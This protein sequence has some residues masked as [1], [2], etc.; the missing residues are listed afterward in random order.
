MFM[1][2][3]SFVYNY[4]CLYLIYLNPAEHLFMSV[5]RKQCFILQH[6]GS[7]LRYNAAPQRFKF[8]QP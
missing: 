8:G 4:I 7:F 5:Y 3:M 1:G 2:G 6:A